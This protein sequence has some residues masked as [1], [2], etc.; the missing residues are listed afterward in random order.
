MKKDPQPQPEPAPKPEPKSTWMDM[1]PEMAEFYLTF[2][3]EHNRPVNSSHV[4]F[5]ASEMASGRFKVNGDTIRVDWDGRLIDGQHRLR[6]IV[7]SGV[8]IHMLVVENLEPEAFV[9][10]DIG[11]RARGCKDVLAINGELSA[12]Q[13][14]TTL[15]AVYRY[16]HRDYPAMVCKPST[17][18]L[19]ALL[20]AHPCLREIS[21]RANHPGFLRGAPGSL[22]LF[23]GQPHEEFLSY[24][25]GA[26]NRGVGLKLD[27]GAYWLRERFIRQK[28]QTGKMSTAV[29]LAL[30]TKAF[31]ADVKKKPVR[32]LSWRADEAF[33]RFV[34]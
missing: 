16:E 3:I 7:K 30:T 9:T 33:P 6:A 24:F 1:T 27:T 22:L 5:L 31:N 14:S 18:E 28:T 26:V 29:T 10:I 11:G 23:Y 34:S 17:Q 32:T 15:Y 4:D 13:L 19:L 8:T 21:K 2:N 25:W 20:E 12:G